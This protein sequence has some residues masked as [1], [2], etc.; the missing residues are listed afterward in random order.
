MTNSDISVGAEYWQLSVH[1]W[2]E[3]LLSGPVP[4]E[5]PTNRR[6]SRSCADARMF[7]CPGHLCSTWRRPEAECRRRA[8][9]SRT[10]KARTS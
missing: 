10:S 1:D 3:I 2:Q 5:A 7:R 8:P 4:K 6:S 9:A